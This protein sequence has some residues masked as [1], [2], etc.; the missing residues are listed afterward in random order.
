MSLLARLVRTAAAFLGLFGWLSVSPALAQVDIPGN[1]STGVTL[2]KY[3]LRTSAINFFGDADW[4]KIS[5]NDSNSYRITTTGPAVIRIYNEAG[6]LAASSGTSKSYVW[7]SPA[8]GNYFVA[9]KHSGGAIGTYTIKVGLYDTSANTSTE[10]R[11]IIGRTATG[12][13][14]N[15]GNLDFL[16]DPLKFPPDE[17]WY[18]VEL[19]T[20]CYHVRINFPL[21]F[22]SFGNRQ[23]QVWTTMTTFSTSVAPWPEAC[24]FACDAAEG[25]TGSFDF[26]PPVA[27]TYF[28]KTLSYPAGSTVDGLPY[29]LTVTE[30]P[31]EACIQYDRTTYPDQ[32]NALTRGGAGCCDPRDPGCRYHW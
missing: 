1:K 15:T 11:M 31:S 25:C 32:W 18:R 17:D 29:S 28:I 3:T 26:V 24:Q 23:Q 8:N 7:L 2:A 30:T 13:M 22:S 5:L 20:S 9:A 21:A 27:G 14:A 12:T 10:R 6:T 16:G 19:G 4:F